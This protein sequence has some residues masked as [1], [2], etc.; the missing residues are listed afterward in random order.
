LLLKRLN[1][2]NS[3]DKIKYIAPLFLL[4]AT[5]CG[6]GASITSTSEP[7]D[8][9]LFATFPKDLFDPY[10]ITFESG[11]IEVDSSYYEMQQFNMVLQE[12][13]VDPNS[14]KLTI[15]VETPSKEPQRMTIY[16]TKD[17]Q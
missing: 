14:I 16:T 9:D 2:F 10:E 1:S 3:M 13:P 12:N 5:G 11:V 8:Y 7:A 17:R 6:V 15:D 4:F